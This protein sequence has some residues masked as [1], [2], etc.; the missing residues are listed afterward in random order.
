MESLLQKL[1]LFPNIHRMNPNSISWEKKLSA[2]LK[3]S[4]I[5]VK[6]VNIPSL[7]QNKTSQTLITDLNLLT[8]FQVS[9]LPEVVPECVRHQGCFHGF[10]KLLLLLLIYL[11]PNKYCLLLPLILFLCLCF[12]CLNNF[13]SFSLCGSCLICCYIPST[14]LK[15]VTK[16]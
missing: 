5:L 13:K 16:W 15:I 11:A 7:L 9:A 2:H 6:L 14:T 1:Y 10:L 4:S 8:A 12:V 3:P